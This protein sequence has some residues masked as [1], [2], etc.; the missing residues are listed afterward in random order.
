MTPICSSPPPPPLPW[1]HVW[2][3]SKP[4]TPEKTILC[5]N[6]VV[7]ASEAPGLQVPSPPPGA[8]YKRQLFYQRVSGSAAHRF[9]PILSLGTFHL[10]VFELTPQPQCCWSHRV[11]KLPVW[12]PR[13]PVVSRLLSP[14]EH[15]ASFFLVSSCHCL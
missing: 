8:C 4:R 13:S 9:E 5:L 6:A 7:L 3:H 14:T 15:P 11:V 10:F 2:N 1:R 12:P